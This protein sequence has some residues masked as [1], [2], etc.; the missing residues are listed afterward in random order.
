MGMLSK[1]FGKKTKSEQET[2]VPKTELYVQV[3]TVDG[4]DQ[5][6]LVLTKIDKTDGKVVLDILDLPENIYRC[7]AYKI[8]IEPI[9]HTFQNPC[10]AWKDNYVPDIVDV[11]AHKDRMKKMFGLVE[12]QD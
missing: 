7:N 10:K 4:Q 12:Q 9:E 5:D 2:T 3:A 6:S 8:T 11:E 1:L